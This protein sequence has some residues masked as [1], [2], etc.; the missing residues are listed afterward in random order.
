MYSQMY[1]LNKQHLGRPLQL[2]KDTIMGISTAQIRG[3]RGLLDWSQAELS[4][5][6][7][8][9]T[10]SIG[11][12]ESGHTQ[13]RESTLTIIRKAFEDSGIEFVEKG[14]RLKTDMVTVLEKQHADDNVFTKLMDDAYSTLRDNPSEMLFGFVDN[15]LSPQ[16][17]VERQILIRKA[18]S[19][20][21]FLVRNNDP[22]Q[23]FALEEYRYLPEGT[24]RNNPYVV[25]G[26][27]VGIVVENYDKVLVLRDPNFAEIMRH[28][29]N[30]IWS[31]C[32]QPTAKTIVHKTAS[33]K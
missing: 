32:K 27:K 29:F 30:I 15:A 8:I 1:S 14:L 28:Q 4:R 5:R 23:R 26:N 11:N 19:N 12:I 18:G 10:T 25:Y 22:F 16:E 33:S 9:S 17:V 21:R 24:Y 13:A 7:G 31:L 2:L 20:M 6:T 3:A